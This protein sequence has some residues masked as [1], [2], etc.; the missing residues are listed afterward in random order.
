MV[1]L[2]ELIGNIEIALSLFYLVWLFSWAKNALG[3]A[4]LAIVFAV[5]VV[6]LTVWQFPI[7]IWL[8]VLLFLFSTFGKELFS[9]M[10]KT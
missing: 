2:Y 3:S 4:K 1:N 10:A 7:L 5:I 9:K 6:F 8:G